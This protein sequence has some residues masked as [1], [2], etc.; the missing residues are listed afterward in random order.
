MSV[1]SIKW[2]RIFALALIGFF[3]ASCDG[4]DGK[5][6]AAGP[7]G[8]PGSPGPTG[9]TGPGGGTS[10]IPVSSA[11]R[12]IV[13]ITNVVVPAGGGAPTVSLRLSNDLDQGL[14]D[15]RFKLAHVGDRHI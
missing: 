12:I 10:G 11:E 6:G 3:V 8:P 13:D 4:S 15:D 2:G 1:Q 9:P 14:S 7:A 5:T